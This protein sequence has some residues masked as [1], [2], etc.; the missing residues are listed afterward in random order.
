[1]WNWVV[2]VLIAVG[3]LFSCASDA[4]PTTPTTAPTT[5]TSVPSSTSV[6]AST[7]ATTRPTAPVVEVTPDYVGTAHAID[8]DTADR[9]RLSWRP[10]CPVE[11]ADLRLLRVS[12][13]DYTGRVRTGELVVHRDHADEL[14]GVFEELYHAAFP[15]ERMELVDVFGADDDASMAANNTS[16]FNCR[17][18]A[19]SPGRWSNHAYGRAID[20]NPLVNPWVTDRGIFPPEGAAFADRSVQVQGGIYA[21][22]VVVQ[23]FADIGW[24]WGGSWSSSKD[25]QHFDVR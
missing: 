1:M 12:Y 13:H 4:T 25:Y 5:V 17:E 20:I 3:L 10:G 14:V 19:G 22:D 2:P 15:I 24:T 16:A 6:T 18:I 8:E 21:G 23:A 7:A 9:M 11:L